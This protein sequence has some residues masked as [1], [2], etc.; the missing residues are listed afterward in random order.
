MTGENTITTLLRIFQECKKRGEKASLFL[1]TKN[2]EEFATFRVNLSASHTVRTPEKPSFGTTAKRKSPSTLKRD[3]KRLE[4]YRTKSLE[5]SC[6]PVK[7][8]TPVMK[9]EQNLETSAVA[10]DF[11]TQILDYGAEENDETTMTTMLDKMKKM[12]RN[13]Y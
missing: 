12:R 5:K 7:T 8:S 4:N 11:G 2:G 10:M 3:R 13:I 6:D 9:F 1:E